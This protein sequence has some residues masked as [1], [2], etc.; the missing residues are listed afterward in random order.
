MPKIACDGPFARVRRGFL[1]P[2][3]C[4]GSDGTCVTCLV[5]AG[6][7][8]A[9]R[10]STIVCGPC[11]AAHRGRPAAAEIGPTPVETAPLGYP[12]G[13]REWFAAL[14]RAPWVEEIRVDGRRNLLLMA[15]HLMLVADWQTLDA[16]PGWDQLEAKTG[17][18]QTTIGRWVQELKLRGWI[19]VLET[20]S[21]PLTRPMA[22][23]LPDGTVLSRLDEGNRRAV[24]A[25]RLPLSPDEALRWAA[26]AVAAEAAQSLAQEEPDGH[27]Q[28]PADPLSTAS[29][30]GKPSSVGDKKGWPTCSSFPFREKT[31]GGYA[32]EATLV[33][34]SW[35]HASDLSGSTTKMDALRAR[36]EEEQAR[37]WATRVPTSGFEML[38]AAGWLRARLPVFA[39]LTRKG[40]RTAGRAFWAAGWTN[41]DIV[42]ALDH[43]P[44]V[45]GARSGT[46]IGRGP[47]DGL[48][49]DQGWWW[50]QTRLAAWRDADGRPLGGYYQTR[51]RRA[52]ARA[53]LIAD[54]GRAA[55]RVLPDPDLTSD[56]V[57]TPE[58]IERFGRRVAAEM[59]AR[60]APSAPAA[61]AT[62]AETSTVPPTAAAILTAANA[63]TAARRE[64]ADAEHAAMMASHAPQIAAARAELAHDTTPGVDPVPVAPALE[65]T[66]EQRYEAARRMAAGYRRDR[67]RHRRRRG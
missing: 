20:G 6:R 27:E 48:D 66:R 45:F 22:L 19:V 60:T 35:S 63:A 49:S 5:R 61:P 37:I 16:M 7:A 9:T 30:Q 32:R 53:A 54:H 1:L 42:H 2:K 23:T 10:L 39:R 14:K 11:W 21:T 46:P 12:A 62:P 38:I 15:R 17:L 28:P 29:D 55:L 65:H 56:Q 33:D 57:L 51:S 4:A 34:N 44:S 58:Q 67:P 64:A 26:Q 40:A 43:L 36:S 24:Y 8:R 59:R 47:G 3:P 18:S 50:I 41:L 52:A 31:Q 13:Q 25:L